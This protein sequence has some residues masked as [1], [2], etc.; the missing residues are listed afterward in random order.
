MRKLLTRFRNFVQEEDG[1]T[2]MEY[3]L[4]GALISIAAIA[5]LPGVGTAV[6]NMFTAIRDAL[7]GGGG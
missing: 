3:V 2:M 7:A 1:V 6:L 4:I 5:V